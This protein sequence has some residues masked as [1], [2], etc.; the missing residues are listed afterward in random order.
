MSSFLI[1]F[2]KV[3]P[4]E[5]WSVQDFQPLSVPSVRYFTIGYVIGV[6]TLSFTHGEN[7]H[8]IL[9]ALC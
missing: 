5:S 6:C 1:L 2:V 4:P 7:I 3:R 8:I 9:S